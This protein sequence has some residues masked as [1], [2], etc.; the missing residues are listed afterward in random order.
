VVP[1]PVLS[2]YPYG[3]CRTREDNALVKGSNRQQLIDYARTGAQARI[4]QLREEL[5]ALGSAHDEYTS[6][7]DR[8]SSRRGIASLDGGTIRHSNYVG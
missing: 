4:E 6:A 1:S 7:G 2:Y 3:L 5:A 8:A